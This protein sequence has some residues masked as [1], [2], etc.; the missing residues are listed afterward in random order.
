[1]RLVN[2]ALLFLAGHSLCVPGYRRISRTN[3]CTGGKYC[4]VAGFNGWAMN[5]SY[6]FRGLGGK[7]GNII[8]PHF[9]CSAG[10]CTLS[11]FNNR[12]RSAVVGGGA[13]KAATIQALLMSICHYNID[14]IYGKSNLLIF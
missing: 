10:T 14:C 4:T 9:L 12:R 3:A 1:M 11:I 6:P 13:Q 2:D 7:H 8:S 5:S